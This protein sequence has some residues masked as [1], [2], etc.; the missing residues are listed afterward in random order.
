M[1]KKLGEKREEQNELMDVFHLHINYFQ[2]EQC[3]PS[4]YLQA[5]T[6]QAT[7]ATLM[8]CMPHTMHQ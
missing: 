2:L 1:G 6:N 8:H 3:L 7:K 4:K 5:Q